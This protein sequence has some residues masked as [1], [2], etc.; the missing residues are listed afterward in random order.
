MTSSGDSKIASLNQGSHE[1]ARPAID[2][3]LSLEAVIVGDD[4]APLRHVL[5][6]VVRN[7]LA[8]AVIVVRVVGLQDA[9]AVSDCQ[10]RGDDEEA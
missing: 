4:D 9:Q 8:G 7:Q 3:L 1:G 10:A 5:E 6:H 2:K